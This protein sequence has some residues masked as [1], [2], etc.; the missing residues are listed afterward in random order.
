MIYYLWP[1]SMSYEIVSHGFLV[2][3]AK[4]PS[5]HHGWGWSSCQSAAVQTGPEAEE[6][7]KTANVVHHFRKRSEL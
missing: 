7:S 4:V 6:C 5:S 1:G 2:F 3:S